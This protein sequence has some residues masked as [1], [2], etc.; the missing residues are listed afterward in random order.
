MN[1]P[2][3][4][5]EEATRRGIVPGAT[6]ICTTS[7]SLKNEDMHGVVANYEDWYYHES[8]WIKAGRDRGGSALFIHYNKQWSRV[9]APAPS[10]GLQEGDACECSP[11]MRAAIIELAK[12]LGVDADSP[13]TISKLNCLSYWRNQIIADQ[14]GHSATKIKTLHTPE[15]FIAK[16]RATAKKPKPIRIGDYTVKFNKGSIEVGC[17]KVDNATVRAIAEKLQD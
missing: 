14:V 17:T 6:V 13:T 15:A 1:V 3:E 7:C 16:M 10:V 8:G 9:V 2:T 11:A 12:E 5:I 4:L